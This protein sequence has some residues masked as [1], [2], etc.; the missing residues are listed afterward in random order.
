MNRMELLLH[1]WKC[2]YD[3][4]DWYP[5]LRDALTGLSA[6]QASWRP[7]GLAANTIWE[8][9]SHLLFF[10]ERLLHRL[11]NTEFPL[12]AETND[13]TFTPS[14]GPDDEEAWQATVARMEQVHRQIHEK[15][16]S[17]TE[18]AFDQPL[19]SIP[20][21]QSVMSIVLHD[22]FHTGQIV[23]IRKLQGTWP[24]KRSFL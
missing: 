20:L 5:P 15:L 16:A 2:T 7:D 24:E 4:E 18:D 14:G 11:Q 10:K 13:D 12:S 3:K 6:A 23:Q 9:V 17:L 21:G 22:A 19:P 1:E 8:N